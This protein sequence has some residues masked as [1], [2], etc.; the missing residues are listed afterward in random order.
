MPGSWTHL[1][2]RFFDVVTAAPLRPEDRDRLN[3]WLSPVEQAIFLDQSAADQ[4]HGLECGLEVAIEHADRPELVRAALL[5]DIGKRHARLGPTGRVL[6]SVLIRLRFPIGA[7]VRS[8]EAHG[9]I[10]SSELVELGAEPLVVDFARHH[11]GARPS[12]I[13]PGDWELLE[14]VDRARLGPSRTP[15][16]YADPPHGTGWQR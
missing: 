14:S 8:Y 10:G 5:H 2:A 13:A 12:S 4:R 11:H 6:A 15:G 16:G 3:E 9:P 7:R 1:V